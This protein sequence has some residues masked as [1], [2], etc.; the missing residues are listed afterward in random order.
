[1]PPREII[2]RILMVNADRKTEMLDFIR[3][4]RD[5]INPQHGENSFSVKLALLGDPDD[6]S[7]VRA[8]GSGWNFPNDHWDVMEDFLEDTSGWRVNDNHPQTDASFWKTNVEATFEEALL[9]TRKKPFAYKVVPIE[10]E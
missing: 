3:S 8:Y 4:Q 9:D 6:G 1:M 7:I 5:L 2:H 10:F